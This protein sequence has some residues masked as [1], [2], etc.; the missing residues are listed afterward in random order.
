MSLFNFDMKPYQNQGIDSSKYSLG[1]DSFNFG[2]TGNVADINSSQFS[3][4]FMNNYS[5]NLLQDSYGMPDNSFN[6]IDTPGIGIN[7]GS[8]DFEP[9]WGQKAF[10][11]TN[12]DSGASFGGFA[13]PAV[14]LLQG[15]GNFYMG[16][17][18]LGLAEDQLKT[19]KQQ[20]SDQFNVQKQLIN[21]DIRNE[22]RQGYAARGNTGMTADEYYEQNKIE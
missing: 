21:Q 2:S 14:G 17:K 4:Q 13:G 9:S 18:Q 3:K 7:P 19:Q 11:Y 16:N 1:A 22:G 10:G 20:F 6:M 12:P 15:A 8:R 5:N